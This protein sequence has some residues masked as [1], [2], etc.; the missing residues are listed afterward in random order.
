MQ[1]DLD[2]LGS[3]SDRHWHAQWAASRRFLSDKK[4][5]C[6]ACMKL[7][8]ELLWNVEEKWGKDQGR[9]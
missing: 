7:K 4:V 9:E 8:R 1:E 5:P 3:E 2:G 6:S